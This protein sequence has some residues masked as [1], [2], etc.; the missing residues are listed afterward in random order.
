MKTTIFAAAIVLLTVTMLTNC[1]MTNKKLEALKKVQNAKDAEIKA[2]QALNL[3]C[4][5]SI[6]LIK[7]TLE[8]RANTYQ[9]NLANYQAKVWNEKQENKILTEKKIAD[10]EQKNNAMIMRLSNYQDTIQVSESFELFR[11]ELEREISELGKSIK[12]ING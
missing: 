6:L 8:E 11:Y 1:Q 5:D 7:K 3:A 12:T 9:K 2:I 10:L 4:K